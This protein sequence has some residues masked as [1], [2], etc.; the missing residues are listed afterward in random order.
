MRYILS[1]HPD[2]PAVFGVTVEFTQPDANTFALK[3]AVVGEGLLLPLSAQP[4]RADELWK[5]TCF[6][7]F[8]AADSG[9]YYEFN[10]SPSTQWAAYR[11]SAYRTGMTNVEIAAPIIALDS[12][13]DRFELM[14]TFAPPKNISGQIALSAVLEDEAGGKSYWAL[15]HA[16]GKPDFHHSDCFAGR[17]P[18]AEQP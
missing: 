5:H 4:M 10:F 13:I 11:F 12:H 16:S 6:E 15:A 7:I 17:L 1:P 2:T 18:A 9:G 8:L 14:A 3:Y